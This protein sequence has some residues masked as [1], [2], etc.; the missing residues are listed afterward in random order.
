[1]FFFSVSYLIENL[2]K[3]LSLSFCS[4]CCLKFFKYKINK[5]CNLVIQQS[6]V[7]SSLQNI[8]PPPSLRLHADEHLGS[9]APHKGRHSGGQR[10][11]RGGAGRALGRPWLG[12]LG[13]RPT[14]CPRRRPRLGH[15]VSAGRW[16]FTCAR[17]G[18]RAV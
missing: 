5:K 10:D 2:W 7:I 4:Y 8:I 9:G 13:L 18:F 1:M 11:C 6:I 14:R 12:G 16:Q 17:A 15:S 3:I